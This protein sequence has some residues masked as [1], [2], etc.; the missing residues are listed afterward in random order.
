MII[1]AY[2]EIFMKF[3]QI[4]HGTCIVE[5]DNLKILIDPILYKKNT[6]EPI[7]GG[8]DQ[9][10]PI[11]D[12][13]VNES[14]LKN[15]D[16]ILLTH[17]HYDHFDPE[18]LQFYG[19]NV[20]IICCIDY[21]KKLLKMGFSNISFVKDKTE[22]N[23]V[24]V[25]LTKGKHGAGIVG[26]SMG[27]SYGFIIKTKDKSVVYITG[28]TIW[29][30]FVEK[31][32]KNY[33]PNYIIGFAGSATIKKVHITLDANDIKNI[34]EIAPNAKMIVNHMDAW[35]HCSLTKEKLKNSIENRNLYIPEDGET[36]NI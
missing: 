1:W 22:I 10:N 16:I 11:I 6:L 18:I 9:R 19:K 17:L 28:D 5:L 4:R 8:I 31:T 36:I 2:K 33:N 34:L 23:G 29:C 30:K 35:N 25:I 32:L 15:I 20:H 27:K 12:I 13:S 3:I 21:K 14:I 26:I 24:E 7:K